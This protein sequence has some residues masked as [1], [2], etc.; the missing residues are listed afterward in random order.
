MKVPKNTSDE[1]DHLPVSHAAINSASVEVPA[2]VGWNLHL[3][4]MVPP[5]NRIQSPPNDRRVLT[6][7]A[8]SESAY[9]CAIDASN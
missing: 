8:Q 3:Y 5:A 7:V 9:A 2:K 6:H 4:A 1:K